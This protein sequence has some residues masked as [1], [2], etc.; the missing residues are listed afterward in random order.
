MVILCMNKTAW[1]WINIYT[2]LKQTIFTVWKQ[3]KMVLW[4]A[5]FHDLSRNDGE[6][7]DNEWENIIHDYSWLI[8][9]VLI[10]SSWIAVEQ[11]F[12]KQSHS[13]N[14]GYCH[15]PPHSIPLSYSQ[16]VISLMLASL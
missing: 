1:E 4:Y 16:I 10:F 13:A 8:S 6:M 5:H 11:E 15:V 9:P 14:L 7:T 2:G 3:E 12:L